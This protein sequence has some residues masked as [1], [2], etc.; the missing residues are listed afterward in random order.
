MAQHRALRFLVTAG[1]IAALT[2]ALAR[3]LRGPSTKAFT[4]PSVWPPAKPWPHLDE[5][6]KPAATPEPAATEPAKP[7]ATPEPVATEPA[8]TPEPAAEPTAATDSTSPEP[9]RRVQVVKKAGGGPGSAK[10]TVRIQAKA[11]A[12]PPAGANW[13]AATGGA[14]PEGYAIKVKVR[15]GLYHEPGMFAYERT[16]PD[17][18][19]PNPEAAEADGFTRAKR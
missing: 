18:C 14:C 4:E 8:T 2:A 5:P 15:S 12:A 7:V 16:N 13:K 1:L 17:R 11:P 10:K 19:Y 6:S 3:W 9:R